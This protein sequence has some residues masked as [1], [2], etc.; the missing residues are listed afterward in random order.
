VRHNYYR[1]E[2]AKT[3]AK[4]RRHGEA[5]AEATE[6]LKEPKLRV[7]SVIGIAELYALAFSAARDEDPRQAEQYAVQ[8]VGLLRRAITEG[9][10]DAAMLKER[11]DFDSL[12][13]RPEFRKLVS[14]L[15]KAN[16]Q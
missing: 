9:Y 11:P 10:R 3:L 15:E 2:R 7:E 12:R 13:Q 4:L 16:G 8:A 5:T 1:L 6:L 14:D